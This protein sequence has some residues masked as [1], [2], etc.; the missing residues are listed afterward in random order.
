MKEVFCESCNKVRAIS[1]N[2]GGANTNI[3]NQQEEL[4]MGVFPTDY[5]KKK[6]LYIVRNLEE[7]NQ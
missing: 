4:N 1:G 5:I 2:T 3:E 7:I 6:R